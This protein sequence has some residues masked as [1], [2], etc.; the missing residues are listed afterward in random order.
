MT[1][2]VSLSYVDRDSQAFLPRPEHLRTKSHV[3]E[4]GQAEDSK[5]FAEVT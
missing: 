1:S 3:V 4:E 5:M 2:A